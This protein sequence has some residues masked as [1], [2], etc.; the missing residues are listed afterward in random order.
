[1]RV[2][3]LWSGYTEC[4]RADGWM[5]NFLNEINCDSEVD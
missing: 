1:M 2:S 4:V 3:E 5:D